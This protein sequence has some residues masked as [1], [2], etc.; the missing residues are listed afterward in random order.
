[1]TMSCKQRGYENILSGINKY[2]F[3]RVFNNV[4]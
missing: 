2:I 1:M 4:F 3:Y